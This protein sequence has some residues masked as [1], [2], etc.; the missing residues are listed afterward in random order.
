MSKLCPFPRETRFFD[1]QT[2]VVPSRQ[3]LQPNRLP[4]RMSDQSDQNP[5]SEGGTPLDLSQLQN[6]SFGPDWSEETRRAETQRSKPARSGGGKR[7]P[8]DRRPDRPPR[9]RPEDSGEDRR[10][11]RRGPPR[12]D[13]RNEKDP[14]REGGRREPRGERRGPSR[15]EPFHPVVDVAFYPEDAPFKALCHAMRGNCRTYELFEIARLILEKPDRFVVVFHPK[16]GDGPQEF[17]VSV[18]DGLPFLSE[19]EA[20]AHVLKHHL[21]RFASTEEVEVDPPKGNFQAVNRCGV[22]GELLGPPNYHRYQALLQQHHAAHAPHMPFERYQAKVETVR[23]EETIQ[24]WVEKMRKVTRYQLKPNEA[25]ETE[26]FDSL[27]SLKFF[28]VHNRR[29]EIVR[30]AHQAR[31]SGQEA[32]A[33]PRGPLRQSVLGWREHQQRFPLETA[34]NLR[35]RLRRLRFTIYKR[36]SKGAS[37]VCAVKR[38][39]RTPR[40]QLSESLQDLIDFIEQHPNIAVGELPEQYLGIDIAAKHPVAEPAEKAPDIESVPE[41]E[42]AKIVEVH[43]QR[44]AEKQAEREAAE[45]TSSEAPAPEAASSS[46]APEAATV[47]PVPEPASAEPPAPQPT[48]SP[49]PDVSE[50]LEDPQLRQLMFDLRW[51]VTEGYVTEFGDGRLFAPPPA[52]EKPAEEKVAQ[53]KPEAEPKPEG[54][55]ETPASEVPAAHEEAATPEPAPETTSEAAPE[56]A[57]PKSAP[58]SEAG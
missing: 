58:S 24:Q 14:R 11:P 46:D 25:G 50:H 35:G 40:T 45:A 48:P 21:D 27:E 18:P 38:K 13:E 23:D 15:E 51:L 9:P 6:L 36:G 56:A 4:L 12:G 17:F 2:V 57:E 47:E 22:S 54:A 1:G 19:D 32:E 33:L 29:Q 53:P 41:E 20:V 34:N 49:A 26:T 7:P 16:P 10:G 42:A 3:A 37:F 39:F 44:R 8:R 43:E 55:V 52:E 5:S 31:F 30:V 28:L